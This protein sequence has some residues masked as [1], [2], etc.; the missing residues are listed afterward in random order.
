MPYLTTAQVAKA[1]RDAIKQARNN[2]S[3]DIP[4]GVTISVTS[5]DHLSITIKNAPADWAW[6]GERYTHTERPTA[7]ARELANKLADLARPFHAQG[8]AFGFVYLDAGTCLASLGQPG[9]SPG[10]D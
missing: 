6:T 8:Y 9:W 4:A 2:G 10:Q 5:R 1:T 7:A 3:L